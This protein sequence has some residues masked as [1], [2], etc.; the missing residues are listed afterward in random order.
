MDFAVNYTSF[1]CAHVISYA[2]LV[3]PM[4][5]RELSMHPNWPLSDIINQLCVILCVRYG[6]GSSLVVYLPIL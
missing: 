2:C 3:V 5:S 6:L 1:L 4:C